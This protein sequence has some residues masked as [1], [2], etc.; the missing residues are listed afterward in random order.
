M[1]RIGAP[2]LLRTD[3]EIALYG[4]YV[5]SSRLER[6]GFAFSYP[7]LPEAARSLL[8]RSKFQC[9]NRRV[10]S[11]SHQQIWRLA[12]GCSPSV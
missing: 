9:F 2:L 3:P 4:R 6:E 12:W 7:R 1:V 10:S 5:K 8:L 11:L